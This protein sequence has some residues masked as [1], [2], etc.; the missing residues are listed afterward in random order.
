[1]TE[2]K[3]QFAK[4]L[5]VNKSTI[6]RY[7]QAG[8]LVLA[9]NGKVKVEESLRLINATKGH[10]S[11]LSEKYG[12]IQ[13]QTQENALEAI[14]E[15]GGADD[16]DDGADDDADDDLDIDEDRV[17]LKA[18]ALDFGN[19]VLKIEADKEAGVLLEKDVVAKRVSADGKSFRVGM[20]R[21]I[22]N[23]APVLV[24]VHGKSARFEAISRAVSLEFGRNV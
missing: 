20:D 18:K 11:D 24:N 23:L 19:R 3:A 12:Q 2:S 22:D 17:T 9:P 15:S 8:R 21:L 5:G 1:M 16:A 7:G 4:R 13:H 6:T 14:L 10:R